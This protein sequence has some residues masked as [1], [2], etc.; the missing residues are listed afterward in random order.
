MKVSLAREKKCALAQRCET[1]S[2]KS[3]LF[4]RRRSAP[5]VC[6]C[7]CAQQMM[8]ND[9]QYAV[10]QLS[11]ALGLCVRRIKMRSYCGSSCDEKG[12]KRKTARSSLTIGRMSE[13]KNVETSA[14]CS[15][16]CLLLSF[17]QWSISFR[18]DCPRLISRYC[19][20][21]LIAFFELIQPHSARLCN[22]LEIIVPAMIQGSPESARS[23]GGILCF[24]VATDLNSH[25]ERVLRCYLCYDNISKPRRASSPRP[26]SSSA[27]P[28]RAQRT[29]S[30]RSAPR[31]GALSSSPDSCK[32]CTPRTRYRNSRPPRR[33]RPYLRKCHY[34]SS[35]RRK[36]AI[37][38][39]A[40]IL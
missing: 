18:S 36:Y 32:C 40:I 3:W 37:S 15:S 29:S 2:G 35:Q 26:G 28:T 21:W 20:F 11:I 19:C 13:K 38:R 1:N 24:H 8:Y 9:M 7:V 4:P 12:R 10:C 22:R 33:R 23:S 14:P 30:S 39:Y 34:P 17:V 27:P 16:R 6:V 31:A 25:K 5:N